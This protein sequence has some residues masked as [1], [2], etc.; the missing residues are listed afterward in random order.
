MR[1]VKE[2]TGTLSRVEKDCILTWDEMSIKE[3]L[4]F[5]KECDT[6]QGI[7]DFGGMDRKLETANEVLVFLVR[8]INTT[9]SYPLSFYFSRDATKPEKLYDLGMEHINSLLDCGLNVRATVCDMAGCNRGLHK[10]LKT[11]K[12]KPFI[13]HRGKKIYVLYDT[14]HIIKCIRNNLVNIGFI[15][16]E[17]EISWEVF[18]RLYNIELTRSNRMCPKLTDNHFALTPLSKMKV[19]YA[20]QV[21]SHS[22]FAAITSYVELGVM[23]QEDLPAANFARRM[24]RIFDMLNISCREDKN[25]KWKSGKEMQ[26]L[27]EEMRQEAKWVST[28]KMIGGKS[29]GSIPS[30]S[31]LQKTLTG[32]ASLILDLKKERYEFIRTRAIQQDYLE[33][34]FSFIRGR[35][36]F[37]RNPTARHFIYTFKYYFMCA[38]LETGSGNCEPSDKTTFHQKICA[39]IHTMKFFKTIKEH[40]NSSEI[41]LGGNPTSSSEE[42]LDA[43]EFD[44]DEGTLEDPLGPSFFSKETSNQTFDLA[45]QNVAVLLSNYAV[46]KIVTRTKCKTCKVS[47]LDF[48]LTSRTC[49]IPSLD[50]TLIANKCTSPKKLYNQNQTM[51]S[52]LTSVV[53]KNVFND[54]VR[55]YPEA[56]KQTLR[57]TGTR[58]IMSMLEYITEKNKSV[59]NWMNEVDQ[60]K[61]HRKDMIMLVLRA[62]VFQSIKQKNMEFKRPKSWDQTRLDLRNQ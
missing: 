41:E 38:A 18:T 36:C 29:V 13:E 17:M 51:H 58:V 15:I 28:W 14:P 1:I 16:D 26:F 40:E 7:V 8:G 57:E 53:V 21:L 9:F 4:Q 12:L 48:L 37:E 2:R 3:Y 45:Q 24:D 11:N 19:K 54:V 50:E 23:K 35:N 25:K 22:V 31:G 47:L 59:I 39:S 33:H 62:K 20:T 5:C 56:L 43:W 44:A 46:K 60:C 52:S 34:F 55:M 42:F 32:M 27:A 10:R 61:A 30:I 6:I 49:G